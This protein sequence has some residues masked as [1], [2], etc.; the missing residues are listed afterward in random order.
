M[1]RLC[2]N[3]GFQNNDITMFCESCGQTI[4]DSQPVAAIPEA[5]ELPH[6]PIYNPP[7]IE[8]PLASPTA[9][10][11]PPPSSELPSPYGAPPPPPTYG[12]P[13]IE[14]PPAL[15]PTYGS[16]GGGYGGGGGGYTSGVGGYTGGGGMHPRPANLGWFGQAWELVSADFGGW[17]GYFV[18]MILIMFAAMIPLYV[19]MGLT[20]AGTMAALGS[21]KSN[22]AALGLGALGAQ[23]GVSSLLQIYVYFVSGVVSVGVASAL[24]RKL[25]FGDPLDVGQTLQEGWSRIGVAALYAFV[26][27]IIVSCGSYLCLIPALWLASA[28]I[29]GIFRLADGAPDF[30]SAF[31]DGL[32]IAKA[33]PLGYILMILVTILIY[34]LGACAC[35]FG[36]LIAYPVIMVAW[37]L[38]YRANFD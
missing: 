1:A 35:G 10:A 36:V 29:M 21:S 2:A 9:Y 3:C 7:A 26:V 37:A 30:W 16:G 28:Q 31:T 18:I 17:I 5:P 11:P 23:M 34:I 25:R 20:Q 4:G 13:P 22:S 33:D 24:L 32:E 12:P 15:P 27:G 14:M 6:A 8:M 19:I 38:A